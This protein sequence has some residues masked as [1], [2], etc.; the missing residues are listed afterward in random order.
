MVLTLV[1]NHMLIFGI[2]AAGYNFRSTA[3]P[4]NFTGKSTSEIQILRILQ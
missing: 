4:R 1:Y 2:S 3:Q